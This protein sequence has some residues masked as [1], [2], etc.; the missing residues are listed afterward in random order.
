MSKALERVLIV[1]ASLAIT[2]VA[3]GFLSGYFTSHDPAG[4]TGSLGGPGL[5]Y[6]DLG[7]KALTP[8]HPHA[9][10]DSNPPT[11]G[12]HVPTPVRS[13]GGILT[14]D[15]ILSALAAG[16]VVVI[17]GGT[18]PPPGLAE[19][20]RSTGGPF[21]PALAAAGEAVILARLP[22][23]PGIIALA[24]TRMLPIP[25]MAGVTAANDGPLKQFIES[26]LGRGAPGSG[27]N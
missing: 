12:A 2:I 21:S 5:V 22:R 18:E 1:L 7:D 20:A 27:N 26:W 24:W 19:L 10:Y 25:G 15:Q 9:A 16:N 17:Y 11:S 6:R 14:N 23:V 3:I 13:D 8:G 4:V